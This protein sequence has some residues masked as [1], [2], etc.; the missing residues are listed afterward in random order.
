MSP[1][2]TGA[3]RRSSSIPRFANAFWLVSDTDCPITIEIVRG[4]ATSIRPNSDSAPT[5]ALKCAWFVF[6]VSNV[7]QVLSVSVIVRPSGCW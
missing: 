6:I 2:K 7:N 1:A 3:V 5:W 4:D